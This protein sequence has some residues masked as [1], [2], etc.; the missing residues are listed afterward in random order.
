MISRRRLMAAGP[1]AAGLATLACVP[2]ATPAAPTVTSQPSPAPAQTANPAARAL[3]YV[4]SNSSPHVSV[5]DAA[6]NRVTATK[7]V[8]GLKVWTWND[9]FNFFD[10]KH[11]WV[12]TRDPANDDVELLTL[13][14]DTLE[15]THRIPLGK[16]KTTL[17]IGQASKKGVLPVAK[18][19]SGQVATI[20]TRTFQLVDIK[21]VPV[22]GG[23]ACDIDVA[24]GP[25]GVERCFIPTLNGDT[26]ISLDTPTSNLLVSVDVPKGSRPVMLTA[27]PDGRAVW[28]Q[29]AGTN[30]N[31]VFEPR[32]LQL[33]KRFPTGK[34]PIVNTFSPDGKLS[35][36]GYSVDT[37]LTVV[38]TGSLE[39]VRNVEVGTSP[40][41]LAVHPN[42]RFV[43]AILTKESAV[44]VVDTSSWQV[45]ARVALAENP[46]GI[47]FRPIA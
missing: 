12:G 2:S 25:D 27:S 24:T 31:A 16:D 37:I 8:P 26:V 5:V 30:T 14:L 3:F 1:A 28:V 45:T 21:D 41:K 39:V 43:Y 47:F 20:D 23:V 40:E 4:F 9:D 7:D 36:I 10:G 46:A 32:A 6:T 19:A 22:N 44:A 11:V 17:Y 34:G 42:G 29:D 38:D 18:H 13:D 35:Y 15:A 33:L